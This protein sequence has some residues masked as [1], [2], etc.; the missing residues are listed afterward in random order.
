MGE[1]KPTEQKPLQ[2]VYERLKH[3]LNNERQHGHEVRTR[4]LTQQ[5]IF[6]LEYERDKQLV[7][8]QTTDIFKS[9]D[10]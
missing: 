8:Q 7:L 10:V 4:I 2:I 3:W 5:L 9:V 6:E 1:D